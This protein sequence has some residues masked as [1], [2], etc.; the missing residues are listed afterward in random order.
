MSNGFNTSATSFE[1][2]R[3]GSEQAPR[4]AFAADLELFYTAD[5]HDSGKQL[6]DIS[7]CNGPRH[8]W[9]TGS[10][11]ISLMHGEPMP[12]PAAMSMELEPMDLPG[13]D[14]LTDQLAAQDLPEQLLLITQQLADLDARCTQVTEAYAESQRQCD[15]LATKLKSSKAREAKLHDE[16]EVLKGQA[17]AATQQAQVAEAET[18]AM[19]EDMRLKDEEVQNWRSKCEATEGREKALEMQAVALQ[20]QLSESKQAAE[21]LQKKLQ[22]EQSEKSEV[23]GKHEADLDVHVTAAQ[24]LRDRLE[25]EQ[26]TKAALEEQLR[27]VQKQL[28]AETEAHAE[29][30]HSERAASA[31]KAQEAEER[32]VALEQERQQGKDKSDQLA[33]LQERIAD[34]EAAAAKREAAEEVA[35]GRRWSDGATTGAAAAAV[36]AG[37]KD[38]VRDDIRMLLELTAQSVAAVPELAFVGTKPGEGKDSALMP[39]RLQVVQTAAGTNLTLVRL[40]PV[41]EPEHIALA[42]VASIA[43]PPDLKLAVDLEFW[44]SDPLRIAMAEEPS[45]AL[46][47]AA[48]GEPARTMPGDLILG[49]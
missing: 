2:L 22:Q 21:D 39:A 17:Q 8:A 1:E 13:E 29:A 31:R 37:H 46:L 23:Q 48:L 38:S 7:G 34:L 12:E 30:L 4:K 32:A 49:D 24:E 25:R 14:L 10:H 5:S 11:R 26:A 33:E 15:N 19:R 9:G 35:Q 45:V 44:G 6:D 18:E 3:A 43:Q 20:S 42:D 16:K 27:D 36:A 28:A 47:I 40:G 41:G